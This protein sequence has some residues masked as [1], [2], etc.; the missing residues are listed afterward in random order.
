MV[1]LLEVAVVID[2]DLSGFSSF[3]G[4]S[5]FRAFVAAL[6]SFEFEETLVVSADSLPT[7][8]LDFALDED[9]I[10]V[11]AG[12][13]DLEFFFVAI[14]GAM[15]TVSDF[16]NAEVGVAAL[17]SL[18]GVAPLDPRPLVGVV[19]LDGLDAAGAGVGSLLE[20]ALRV[21]F[22]CNTGDVVLGVD[23]FV[24]DLGRADKVD[25]LAEVFVLIVGC[26]GTGGDTV[27]SL[28]GTLV[29]G[30]VM[31]LVGNLVGDAEAAVS[32]VDAVVG[33]VALNSLTGDLAGGA[34]A[35]SLVGAVMGGDLLNS[36]T[37]ATVAIV[38]EN[39]VCVSAIVTVVAAIAL[40]VVV[41]VVIEALVVVVVVVV[42][43]ARL[44]V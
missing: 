19:A 9:L 8:V 33:V 16:I 12:D 28:I 24:E 15:L 30:A 38:V 13:V 25:S 43:V 26:G 36:F 31:S 44:V 2:D 17:E 34:G 40:A 42:V 22:T 35:D 11:S 39:E 18:F 29:W 32:L 10:F 3:S 27:E 5:D 37:G 4:F 21:S 20:T 41:D 7:D 1:V 14:G 6:D 23:S